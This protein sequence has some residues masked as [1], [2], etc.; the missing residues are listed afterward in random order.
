MKADPTY[1]LALVRQSRLSIEV[2]A[3][4][5]SKSKSEPL[6][7]VLHTAKEDAAA[8]LAALATVDPE[9]AAEIRRLQNHVARFDD[10][11]TW[12]RQMLTDGPEAERELNELQMQET[13][14][15][16]LD[17]GDAEALGLSTEGEHDD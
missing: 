11:V 4:V 7:V 2:E 10:M 8:A 16:I 12:L 15:L 3:E 6:L 17:N 14:D 9:N 5:T 1:K 13:R